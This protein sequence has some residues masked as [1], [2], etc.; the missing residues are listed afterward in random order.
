MIAIAA[1]RISWYSRSVSVC[2]GA[3]VIESPVCTPIGSKFSIE[4]M[5]TTL[6]LLVAHHLELELLPAE[7]RSPRSGPRCSATASRPRAADVLELLDVV[8]DAA[9]RA[10]QREAGPD[11]ARQADLG[12]RRRAPRPGCGRRRERGTSRP[13]CA[14]AA[15]NRSRSSALL[16]RRR[17]LAPIISTPNFVEH[18]RCRAAASRMFSPVWPPSVGSSASGRSFSMILATT[19]GVIGSM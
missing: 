3:T 6:S 1:S 15:R 16:D 8:G 14:I 18:A 17:R 11:D 19:S 4:Q 12:Q 10:A 5:M 7:D 2:A 9:A 13:S